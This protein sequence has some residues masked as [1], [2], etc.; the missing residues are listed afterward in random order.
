MNGSL[1]EMVPSLDNFCKRLRQEL[2]RPTEKDSCVFQAPNDG[3]S[4]SVS[5]ASD[6]SVE[7]H[8]CAS[9]KN[10]FKKKSTSL[11]AWCLKKNFNN[12]GSSKS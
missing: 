12:N 5:P 9:N 2:I 10:R 11:Y 8:R 1:A 6:L 4:S 7:D 3:R